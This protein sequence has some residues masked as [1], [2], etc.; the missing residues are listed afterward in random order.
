M[1][2]RALDGLDRLLA[3]NYEDLDGWEADAA[4]SLDDL[5]RAEIE[6]DDRALRDLLTVWNAIDEP[7]PQITA[8][9]LV[10]LAQDPVV[11][12]VAK[13]PVR[14]RRR[15]DAAA[16]GWAP[17]AALAACL[18][19]LVFGAYQ[20]KLN[21]PPADVRMKALT[22]TAPAAELDLQFSVETGA[23]VAAGQAGANLGAKDRLALRVDVVGDGGWLYLFEAVD[24]QEP[25]AIES[26]FVAAPGT[27]EIGGGQ[28][29]QPDTLAG[30]TTYLAVMTSE[31]VDAA[32]VL[33]AGILSAAERPDRWPRPVLAA[34]WFAVHWE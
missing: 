7:T 13:S 17:L 15:K 6:A 18:A 11:V 2:A 31:E 26:R 5:E 16:P 25:V 22:P 10:G 27:V 33:V 30:E 29:W 8:A 28:V 9:D 1:N 24:G 34:D 3:L 32:N 12:P 21:A 14:H 20:L 4:D 23:V 19:V